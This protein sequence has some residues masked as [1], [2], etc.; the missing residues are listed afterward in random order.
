VSRRDAA[1]RRVAVVGAGWAG[2]AAAVESTQR[3]HAVTLYEMAA[4]AGGRA[5]QVDQ[6]GHALD[7]G[8]HILI[9]AYTHT[10][11]LMRCVGMDPAAA[12]LRMPMRLATPDGI[13]LHLPGGP[14][15]LAFMRGVLA[16]RGWRLRDKLQLLSTAGGWM[17]QGFRCAEGLS[18]A[19]LTHRLPAAVREFLIDPLCVAALNTPAADASGTVFLRVLHD[20]LA[21]GPSSADLL[22][23]RQRLSALLPDPALRWLA[24]AGG[25]IRLGH[26]VETLAAHSAGWQ[27]DGEAFDHVILAASAREAARLAQPVNPAWAAQAQALQYEPIITVYLRSPGTRLPQPM[28][29]LASDATARPAQFV[30][31]HSHLDGSDGLLAF[32]ISGAQPWV[33]QGMEATLNATLAQARQ[34]LA[35]GLRSPLE[36]VRVFTEKRATFRCTPGL[37]RPAARVAAGLGAAGDHV[38][39]PYPATLEGAVRSGQQAAHAMA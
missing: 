1:P 3:G 5:R 38:A 8:Q 26:R 30:F 20:A 17:L 27:V 34:A 28:A 29:L 33:D 37:R 16:H 23:P 24:S 6:D 21:S 32:V 39:G 9:G 36:V 19:D 12:F 13:G 11:A 31:D 18:V 15:A 2:L 22:L 10:L 35:Q 4:Q 7:N 14:P 25:R